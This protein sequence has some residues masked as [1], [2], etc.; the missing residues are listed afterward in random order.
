LLVNGPLVGKW[1][2]PQKDDSAK[3]ET[4]IVLMC[5]LPLTLWHIARGERFDARKLLK[6]AV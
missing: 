6:V 4:V 2:E 3:L 5:K 1:Y